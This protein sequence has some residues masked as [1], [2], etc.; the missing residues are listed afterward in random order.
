MLQ[1]FDISGAAR[2]EMGQITENIKWEWESWFGYRYRSRLVYKSTTV[3]MILG[4]VCRL[5]LFKETLILLW[6]P[7]S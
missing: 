2:Q 7:L 3:K 6:F 1:Q 5:N 4:K